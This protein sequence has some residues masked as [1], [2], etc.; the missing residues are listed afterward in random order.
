MAVTLLPLLAACGT[1]TG[2][3][4]HSAK[5]GKTTAGSSGQLDIPADANADLKKQYLLENA[6]AACMKKQG[7]TYTAVAPEDPAASWTT[8][9]A[10]YALTKKY[11]QKYGFGIYSGIVYPN[12]ASSPGSTA[13]QKD[14]G[15][16]PNAAYVDTL[17]PEQKTAYNKALGTPPDPKTGEKGWTGCQG[18][19]DRS[20]YGSAT[21]QERSTRTASQNQAN[22]QALNGDPKLVGLAQSYA[23][24]LTKDGISV[25]TTQ[26]TGI[27]DMVRLQALKSAPAGAGGVSPVG[28]DG[29]TRNSMSKKDALP[30]LTKDIQLA[31][32]DL[33]CGKE[34]RAAYFPKF[35]KAPT[36]GGGAG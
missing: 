16:T 7:F 21:A 25:T 4:S 14:S 29:N 10:D 17:T 32:Q 1:G 36:S 6:I 8:D 13:A 23:S 2:S 20:V 5:G 19:A 28:D 12:D 3:E 31:M 30:L 34:F 9:G 24:C 11:R 26:P 18:E 22:A 33:K 35:L 15:R 27:G